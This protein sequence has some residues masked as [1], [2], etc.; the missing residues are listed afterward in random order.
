M[1]TFKTFFVALDEKIIKHTPTKKIM[2][3]TAA[4]LIASAA[5]LASGATLKE[6]IANDARLADFHY[7]L[8]E[9]GVDLSS[10]GP[11]TVF[12]PINGAFLEN[13][14]G[15]SEQKF[16][17]L[18]SDIQKLTT[19]M[20]YHVLSGKAM[21]T[22]DLPSTLSTMA[23]Q[24]LNV[25]RNG[26]NVQVSDNACGVGQ[27]IEQDIIGDNG[28]L[29]IVDSAFVPA[30]TFCPDTVFAT[31]GSKYARYITAY[32]YDC[33]SVGSV[34]LANEQA[35]KPVALATSEATKS[36]FWTDDMDY[37]HGS[38]TSWS[39][40]VKFDGTGKHHVIDNIID[41]QGI[42]TDDL[43]KKL[44]FA[45]H[46]GNSILRTNYDGTEK[47]TLVVKPQNM[48][49]QPS[50]V[51]VD[52]ASGYVF[53]SIEQPNSTGYVAMF[54]LNN[55]FSEQMLAGPKV[56][57]PYGLCVDT[58]AQHVYYIVGGHGGSIRCVNYGTTPCKAPVLLDIVDYAYNC[59]VDN[60]MASSGGPTNI[61]FSNADDIYFVSSEGGDYQTLNRTNVTTPL[62]APMGVA[63]GC[64]S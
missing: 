21:T 34:N 48:S 54:H 16:K 5:T 41:P 18:H 30:G 14:Q 37:P 64:R 43:N 19:M 52:S 1:G 22:D 38:A 53:A 9:S 29:H 57:K 26:R 56:G 24:S 3:T 20:Q 17:A 36:V 11:F 58:V 15:M 25:Q 61:V 49:F 42:A 4:L 45:T 35:T 12:A 31:Q 60:S 44:Y 2:R 28:I 62:D 8:S 32:G 47:E 51:A 59:A 10:E 50:G 13:S 55:N 6:I 40:S 39:S 23:G 46:S 33:R 63:F 27:V 7:T